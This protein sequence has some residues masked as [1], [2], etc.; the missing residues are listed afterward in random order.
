MGFLSELWLPILLSA[1]FVFVASSVLHMALPIHKGDY[2]KLPGEDAVLAE[3]R[4]QG[5]S[6][7][8]YM[9]PCAGSMKDMGSPEMIEKFK[10]GPVGILTVMPSGPP[11]I[12][13]NLLQ[14]FLY[15]LLVGVFVAYVARLGLG[16]GAA[17]LLVFRTTGAVAVLGYAA[18]HIVNSIW[19]GQR[20]GVTTKFLFD[21]VVYG[22]LTAG[23][24]GWLWPDA[25]A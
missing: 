21:G 6:P 13:K 3:L 15:C 23:T 12:G 25:A 5:V 11:N 24:F 9:L 8:D 18:V 10:R 19:K 7:G 14:W 17:Y 16:A 2:R 1:V 4:K 20:W 22:L